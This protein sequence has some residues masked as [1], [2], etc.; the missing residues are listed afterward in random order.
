MFCLM[1]ALQPEMK[2]IWIILLGL[3]MAVESLELASHLQAPDQPVWVADLDH[4]AEK[5]EDN[6]EKKDEKGPFFLSS[7]HSFL[8]NSAKSRLPLPASDQL[9]PV[10]AG[11]IQ[12]PP[13]DFSC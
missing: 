9:P 1:L 2:K 10:P 3:F 12:T 7:V 11:D 8:S 6:K 5:A 13:P 4:E